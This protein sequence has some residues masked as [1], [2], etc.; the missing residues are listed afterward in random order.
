M[1]WSLIPP[2]F[3]NI[4]QCKVNCISIQENKSAVRQKTKQKG[5]QISSDAILMKQRE[6]KIKS[7]EWKNN[8][9]WK[10]FL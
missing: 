7:K 5:G 9:K 8:K 3:L 2:A 10:I 4:S 6:K 1:M